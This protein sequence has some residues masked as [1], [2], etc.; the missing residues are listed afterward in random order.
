[1]ASIE[2][3]HDYYVQTKK[4]IFSKYGLEPTESSIS[5][6]ILTNNT[7]INLIRDVIEMMNPITSFVFDDIFNLYKLLLNKNDLDDN[8]KDEIYTIVRIKFDDLFPNKTSTAIKIFEK[9][10]DPLL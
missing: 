8:V 5:S 3:I 4:D 10:T 6:N 9:F 7:I 2:L 1:M